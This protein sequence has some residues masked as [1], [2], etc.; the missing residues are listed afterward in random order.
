MLE[1]QLRLTED[2]EN[3]WHRP[4]NVNIFEEQT[5]ECQKMWEGTQECPRPSQCLEIVRA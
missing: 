4:G 5:L 1:F 2:T 3:L